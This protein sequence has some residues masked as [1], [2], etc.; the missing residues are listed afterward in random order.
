MINYFSDIGKFMIFEFIFFTIKHV[1][2][3]MSLFREVVLC[4]WN[5][6]IGLTYIIHDYLE[7]KN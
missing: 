6:S 4:L 2:S 3:R 1:N 7:N 5:I